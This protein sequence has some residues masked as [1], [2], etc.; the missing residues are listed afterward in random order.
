[1][2]FFYLGTPTNNV[3]PLA[4]VEDRVAGIETTDIE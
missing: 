2:V 4:P 1:V 3:P